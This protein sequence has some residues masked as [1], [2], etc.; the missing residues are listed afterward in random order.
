MFTYEKT[1]VLFLGGMV[2]AKYKIADTV[3]EIL[4]VSDYTQHLCKDF[5]VEDLKAEH[6]IKTTVEEVR[7][8]MKKEPNF[9]GVYIES[10]VVFRRLCDYLLQKKKGIIFH[11]SAIIVNGEAYLF[12]APSGTGKSTHARLWRELLKEKAV[13]LNDDKPLIR[14][15]GNQFIAYGSPWNGKHKLGANVSAPIKAICVLEQAKEN[16][17]TK[18]SPKEMLPVVINQTMYP[19]NEEK[20]DKMLNLLDGLLKTVNLYKLQCNVSLESAE[21]S[22][23]VMSKGE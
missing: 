6:T 13:M 17:I 22:F 11:S 15:I 9:P 18:I 7:E 8:E 2:M 20:V 12:T 19:N 4:T 10:L 1:Q 23:N 16:K 14:Q 3:F 5:L 21:L